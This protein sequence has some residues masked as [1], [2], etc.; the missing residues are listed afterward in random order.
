VRAASGPTGEALPLERPL[1]RR[2]MDERRAYVITDVL[3]DRTARL[4]SFGEGN[5][6]EL[7]FA[8][9]VKTGT[10]KGY[11]DNVTVGYTP[12][13]TV[14]VWVGN[15][16]GSPM[17][18]VSGVSGAGPLFH[19]ALVAASRARPPTPFVAPDGMFS[20]EVCA[21]SG[22]RPTAS[23]PHRKHELFAVESGAGGPPASACAMHEAVA[24]DRRTELRAGPACLSTD[25]DVRVFEVF[26]GPLSAWARAAGRALAPE[27]WSPLCPGGPSDRAETRTPL[28]ISFPLDG[29]RFAVDPGLASAQS[30]RVRAEA[31]SGTARLRFHVDG[32]VL[33]RP[34]PFFLDLPLVAGTH[35]LRVDADGLGPSEPVEFTVD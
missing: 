33:E 5:V 22:A 8:A 13:V 29:A 34:A 14:A 32:R 10:S 31:P 7:P 24:I 15:F 19:D 20:A 6:L 25:V 1:A 16:D 17:A 4:A 28:R 12:E 30:I 9:A 21:L 3:S 27:A 23:C 26:P 18:G 11:R 35:V 2:V